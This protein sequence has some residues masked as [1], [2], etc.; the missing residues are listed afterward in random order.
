MLLGLGQQRTSNCFCITQKTIV[1]A[2]AT[3]RVTSILSPR[4]QQKL[5][6]T[7]IDHL[8]LPWNFWWTKSDL[9]VWPGLLI[10]STSIISTS[11][12]CFWCRTTVSSW[13][14]TVSWGGPSALCSEPEEVWLSGVKS[15]FFLFFLAFWFCHNDNIRIHPSTTSIY[16]DVENKQG[17]SFA[18]SA[19]GGGGA[20][21]CWWPVVLI[22]LQ[23]TNKTTGRGGSIIF[24]E[25]PHKKFFVFPV[26]PGGHHHLQFIKVKTKQVKRVPGPL[27]CE[28]LSDLIKTPTA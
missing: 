25:G 17:R 23:R 9:L 27:R 4:N 19:S 13:Q 11:P 7:S 14:T 10:W 22:L 18:T 20:S 12:S 16:E 26:P 2:A 1:F 28:V 5:K 15:S 6:P 3:A 8:F 24:A 21:C